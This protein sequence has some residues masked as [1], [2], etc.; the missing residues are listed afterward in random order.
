MSLRGL[1]LALV[2]AAGL[3]L[4]SSPAA[5]AP[6]CTFADGFQTLHD[7]LPDRVGDCASAVSYDP[8]SGDGLQLTTGGVLLWR[9]ADNWTGFT[10]GATTWVLGPNGLESRPADQRLPWESVP[11]GAPGY[12]VGQVTIGPLAPLQTVG[13]PP[14]TPTPEQCAAYGLALDPAD[15]H[16]TA[17]RLTLRADCSYQVA[18]P[19]GSYG[20]RLAPEPAI[21]GSKDLPQTVTIQAG[22]A[23]RLDVSIDT[24]IR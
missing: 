16:A 15:G 4:A 20:V 5:A 22:Q 13:A 8:R 18:L 2:L 12:L 24:G 21:G 14:P 10:D 11:P 9:K 23:L 3:V 6:A 7:L 19:A 1:L 17:T